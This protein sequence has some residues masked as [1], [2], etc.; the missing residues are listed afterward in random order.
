MKIA[1]LFLTLAI[2]PIAF[3]GQLVTDNNIK[4]IA[5]NGEKVK[6]S[7][8]NDDAVEVKDG[9]QQVVLRYI[10]SFR[11]ERLIE[12]RPYILT[13]D[14]AGKTKISTNS[15]NS[16]SQAE[17]QIRRGLDW[18]VENDQGQ[19][20]VEDAEELRGD[21]FM[22]YSDIEGLIA[23]YNEDNNLNVSNTSSTATIEKVTTNSLIEQYKS[24]TLEQKKQFKI[25]LLNSETK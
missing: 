21:G 3:A 19:Y 16:Y 12:S 23:Q 15:L 18:N 10:D 9:Q 13:V 20:K 8:G 17:Q 22:P 6:T 1:G 5:L 4:I 11:G 2:S 24:A 25:W 7:I 14:V